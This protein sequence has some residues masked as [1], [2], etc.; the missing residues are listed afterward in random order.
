MALSGLPDDAAGARTDLRHL[1]PG[2]A[3]FTGWVSTSS[4]S[5]DERLPVGGKAPTAPPVAPPSGH[6][7]DDTGAPPPV[8][9]WSVRRELRADLPGALRIVAVLAA[10]G[11]P[12]GVLWWALAPRADFRITGEGPVAVGLPPDELLVADDAVLALV[13]AGVG[14][15]SGVAVW[16][17][18]RRRGVAAVLALAVGTSVAAVVAWQVGELLGAGPTEVELS[19]VGAQVT[20]AL[21]LGSLPALAVAPFMA[22]LAYLAATLYAH[23]D[24]LG[25]ASDAT[26]P[27]SRA[28]SLPSG[29][30]R[31]AP[32]LVE[33]PAVDGGRPLVDAPPPGRPSA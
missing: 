24:G 19:D 23:D 32:P 7:A 25:R 27:S 8:A 29:E 14:L 5:P 10:V 13:L 28:G 2:R 21:R 26:A 20:T 30:P 17:L 18:R 3:L 12:A 11:L 33:D 6:G 9:L 15:L 1:R 22:I 31:P 16:L 4:P